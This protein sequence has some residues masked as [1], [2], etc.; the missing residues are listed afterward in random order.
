ME[1]MTQIIDKLL[2]ELSIVFVRDKEEGHYYGL[3]L[4]GD[5]GLK[6]ELVLDTR[7]EMVEIGAV[8]YSGPI[9]FE[10]ETFAS[11]TSESVLKEVDAIVENAKNLVNAIE[12]FTNKKGVYSY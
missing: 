2:N 3:E 4:M 11:V 1:T 8:L 7:D 12:I 6:I 10:F 9:K 5:Y